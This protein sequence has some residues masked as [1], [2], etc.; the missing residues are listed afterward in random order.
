ML[1]LSPVSIFSR[2][3]EDGKFN[4]YMMQETAYK[5]A[6]FNLSVIPLNYDK[7]PNLKSWK[8]FQEA[9]PNAF[10]INEM[11]IKGTAAIGIIGGKVSG[12][13]EILDEDLKY[14][15]T[16]TL[17]DEFIER[18]NESAPGL[19]KKLL[20]Q[21]TRNNGFHYPY[22]CEVI[23]G[24]LK[25]ASRP[26]SEEEQKAHPKEKEKTL[27]ETRGEGGYIAAF[28]TPGYEIIQG[29]FDKIPTLT[30]AEREILLSVARSFNQC[31]KE[32]VPPKNKTDYVYTGLSPLVDYNQ[33][34][35]VITLLEKHGWTVVFTKGAKTFLK[36]PGSTNAK[37]SANFDADKN[38]FTVFSTS[39]EFES[40]K[41]YLPYA[42]FAILECNGDFSKAAHQLYELNFGDRKAKKEYDKYF[43]SATNA[44]NIDPDFDVSQHIISATDLLKSDAEPPRYILAPLLPAYGTAVLAGP[45]DTGKSQFARQLC[46]SIACGL[47]TFLNYNLT[48]QHNKALYIATEDDAHNTAYLMKKQL[49]ALNQTISDNLSLMIA[50][51]L[52]QDEILLAID[53][54]LT[55][56]PCDLVVVDSFGDVFVGNDTNSTQQMRKNVKAFDYFAKKHKCLILFVHHINKSS[57]NET[58]HQKNIMG[59]GGFTQK[60]RFAWQLT[61]GENGTKTLTVVKGN[62]CPREYK[63]NSWVLNFSEENF[64]FT[65]TDVKIP[66]ASINT[67]GKDKDVK[68]DKLIHLANEIFQNEAISYKEFCARHANQT[69]K[70]IATAKRDHKAMKE[71]EIIIKDPENEKLWQLN[72]S[73]NN[74]EAPPEQSPDDP[75]PC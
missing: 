60:V 43:K 5:Y 17:H 65:N 4:Y 59:G 53:L 71:L 9:I 72:G 29:S 42:V 8:P 14:D 73:V 69:A 52:T 24:N 7:S 3:S 44:S 28:P 1:R 51:I 20:I 49:I 74:M 25:L 40:Q 18:L 36:R 33:R 27:F 35:D 34:G 47:P 46:I 50:D 45:P 10:Q 16:G 62:Y 30:L 48:L 61:S 22:Y 23:E 64:L 67:D 54:H 63:E 38:W 12:N 37:Q 55:K 68:F 31:F 2:M 75:L 6:A 11:F 70:G 66:T 41:A 13:L 21:K 39:T 32:Y 15:L 19:Y 58:P 57:Y 26:A 56:Y